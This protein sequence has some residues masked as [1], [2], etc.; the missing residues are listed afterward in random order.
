MGSRPIID[1]E[2]TEAEQWALKG[3]EY[4]QAWD[5]GYSKEQSTRPQ[6]VGYGLADSPSGQVTTVSGVMKASGSFTATSI[7][8]VSLRHPLLS[9][10]QAEY[11]VSLKGPTE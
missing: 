7:V 4:Y 6:T 2:P 11:S 3:A 8:S 1:G 5:S 9:V 10:A